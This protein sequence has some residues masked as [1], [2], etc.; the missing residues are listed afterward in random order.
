VVQPGL[1]IAQLEGWAEGETLLSFLVDAGGTVG[2]E[3]TVVGA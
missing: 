1:D 2:A 3:I